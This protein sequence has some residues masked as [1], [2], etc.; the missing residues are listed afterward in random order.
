MA[1]CSPAQG[2]QRAQGTG[3]GGFHQPHLGFVM[4]AADSSSPLLLPQELLQALGRASAFVPCAGDGA[5]QRPD[6][7]G[8][9]P[10]FPEGSGCVGLGDWEQGGLHQHPQEIGA[11]WVASQALHFCSPVTARDTG[12]GPRVVVRDGDSWDSLGWRGHFCSG[13]FCPA[14]S[15]QALSAPQITDRAGPAEPLQTHLSLLAGKTVGK[16]PNPSCPP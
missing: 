12:L 2:V 5:A 7:A 13:H 1:S 11:S 9:Q 15:Q 6:T 3:Q 4:G 14:H 8:V 16:D 10:C